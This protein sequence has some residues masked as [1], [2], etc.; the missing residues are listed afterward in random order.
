MIGK[1]PFCRR[2]CSYCEKE[3]V[4]LKWLKNVTLEVETKMM[5]KRM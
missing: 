3:G 5:T 2:Q 1:L 4:N